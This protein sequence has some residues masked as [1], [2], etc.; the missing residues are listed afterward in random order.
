MPPIVKLD[1][2]DILGELYFVNK[3][4]RK[5]ELMKRVYREL[6]GTDDSQANFTEAVFE[7]AIAAYIW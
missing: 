4:E 7:S 1:P 6:A 3:V 5:E 2:E